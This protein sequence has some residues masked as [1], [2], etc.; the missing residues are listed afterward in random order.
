M[1]TITPIYDDAI[2]KQLNAQICKLDENPKIST[3]PV[4]KSSYLG[5]PLAETSKGFLIH[6]KE[7]YSDKFLAYLDS[8]KQ[9]C[10]SSKKVNTLFIPI[11]RRLLK[12]YEEAGIQIG[13]SPIRTEWANNFSA[14]PDKK[15]TNANEEGAV[16][17]AYRFF[18]DASSVQMFFLG[19]NVV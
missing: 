19:Y 13:N 15:N 8:F 14:I 17:H 10:I 2:E 7:N 4:E 9:K 12:H 18:Y 6:V 1:N 11:V 3:N 5:F 16:S